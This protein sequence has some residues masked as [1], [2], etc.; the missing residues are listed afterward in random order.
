MTFGEPTLRHDVV[1]STQDVARELARNGATPGTVVAAGYQTRGRGRRGRTWHAP[2]GANVCL[3]AIGPPTPASAAWQIA[4][5]A[6]LAVAEAVI[7]VAETPAR[8]RFPN[9]VL[10]GASKL[11][12]VLVETVERRGALLPLIGIG[13]NVNV[14]EFPPEIRERATS[15]ERATGIRRDVIAVERAILDQLDRRWGEWERGGPAAILAAWRA[16]LAPN[17]PRTFLIE[18]RPVVCRVR[19]LAPDG[20]LTVETEQG[21]LRDLPATSV[22]LDEGES[23]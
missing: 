6:G 3:T 15:L 16:L 14:A 12:G 4:L 20:T 1:E 17:A 7:T 18:N 9:D 11:A 10:L 21:V 23:G 13:V 22:F 19:D 5:L 2:P 8:V